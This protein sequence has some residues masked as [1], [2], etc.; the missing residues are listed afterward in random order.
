[1]IADLILLWQQ[2]VGVSLQ[3]AVVRL[4]VYDFNGTVGEN[5]MLN[6]R[7]EVQKVKEEEEVW[8]N[9]SPGDLTAAEEQR[10]ERDIRVVIFSC[11]QYLK[12]S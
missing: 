9:G 10:A 4:K 5:K 2:V 12:L 1:M 7:K 3:F 11:V 6:T 8:R